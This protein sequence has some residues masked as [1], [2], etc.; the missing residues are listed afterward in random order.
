MERLSL[1]GA[2]LPCGVSFLHQMSVRDTYPLHTHDFYEVFYVVRGCAMHDVNGAG[3]ACTAGTLALIRPDDEHAYRFL[4]QWDMELISIGVT[5][6]VMAEALAYTG[7]PAEAVDAPSLPPRVLLE[8]DGQRTVA[9]DL[10]KL[11]ETADPA[12]RRALG[13]ALLARLLIALTDPAPEAVR[14]PAWLSRLLADMSEPENFRQGLPRMIEMSHVTQSHLGR[15]MKRCLGLTPT[16][17]INEKRIALAGDL[18]LTGQ[19]TG[20]EVA[21]QCGFETLSHFHDCFRRVYGCAPREFVARHGKKQG[22]PRVP[23][24]DGETLPPSA[25]G[26]PSLKG[27]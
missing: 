19:Y 7:V 5:R 20:I 18:L 4:N 12:R 21:G 26:P 9:R 13:K 24:A 17:F 15:E 16:A 11:G 27:R 6:A 14:L 10:M 23:S 3:E 25:D 1:P 8:G 22:T 2:D